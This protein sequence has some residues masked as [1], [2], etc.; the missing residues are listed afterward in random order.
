MQVETK[1]LDYCKLSF[2]CVCDEE[3]VKNK[4]SE[5]VSL[6]K[7]L[8]VPGFRK[9]KV[10]NDIIEVYFKD[11]IKQSLQ[12]A[13]AEY[14]FHSAMFEKQVQPMGFPEFTQVDL[15]NNKFTC[16]FV[17]NVKPT[18]TLNKYF[19]MEIPFVSK[20]E[21]A[22]DVSQKILQD[23][24]RKYSEFTPY[25][26]DDYVQEGDNIVITYTGYV[27]DVKNNAISAEDELF[28]VGDS[29]I[30]EF[31]S[32]LYGLKLGEKKDIF[33]NFPE[34]SLPSLA[35]KTI[36][37]EIEVKSG[38]KVSLHP[39][40][41]ELAKKSGKEDLNDLKKYLNGIAIAREQEIKN[42]EKTD[43]ICNKL[44][45]ENNFQIPTWLS[46]MEAK[47]L[48][49]NSKVN[50][51]TL[52]DVD[53]EK[54]ISMAERNLRLSFILEKIREEQPEAQ[55]TD[56]EVID[57]IKHGISNNVASNKMDQTMKELF[58]SGYLQ[59]MATKVKDEHTL[60]FLCK[61]TKFID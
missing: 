27:N 17:S 56:S 42:K 30:K 6:F 34:D 1:E 4:K 31:D 60:S 15:N 9:G 39:V 54:F 61:N 49:S 12:K 26:A 20:A 11:Q 50:W 57:I 2:H 40:D 55:L 41:D 8:Q 10:P 36:K 23:L 46:S 5:I 59:I 32:N 25:T 22:L 19:E 21:S 16:G 7:K 44:V 47:Y 18:F 38:M 29:P 28:I 37:F 24:R 58:E 14:V 48:A 13:M 35:N 52:P 45:A 53:K 3:E 33:I 51:D 43:L